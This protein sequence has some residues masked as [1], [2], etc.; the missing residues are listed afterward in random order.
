MANKGESLSKRTTDGFLCHLNELATD[1]LPT[2]TCVQS[3]QLVN[4][5]QYDVIIVG[6]GFAGLIAARELSLRQ[7]KVLLVEAKDRIGGRTFTAEYDGGK[8]EIGGTWVHWSQ[9]HVWT[10]ITRYGL[11]IIESKGVAAKYMSVLLDNGTKLKQITLADHWATLGKAMEKY[12]DVDNVQA[13]MVIP[14][15]HAPFTARENVE[16]Y[17]RLSMQD[18]F[19]QVRNTLNMTDE[20]QAML[21]ALL[22]MNMQ[23]NIAEGGFVDHLRWWALGDYDMIRMFDKLGRYKIKEGTSTLAQAILNDCQNVKLLLS[24]SV[25]SVDRTKQDSV[26]VRLQSGD[27]ILGRT[28]LVT[29]PLNV[30]KNIEFLPALNIK[31]QEI[32]AKGQCQGGTKFWAKLDKPIGHWF[33]M[34]PYPNP[35]TMAYTDDQ[36]GSVIVGFGP[37]GLLDIK[38]IKSVEKELNKFLPAVKAQYVLGHDWRTDPNIMG[39]WSWYKPGQ[40]CSN[41]QALQT[42]E[43]PVFFASGDIANGWRGFIDGALESGL[44]NAREIQQY[45]NK[46][47]TST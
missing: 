15:P 2:L 41:L 24:T 3:Q 12:S 25:V 28:V 27:L 16:K 5:E 14:L 11:S 34:A 37:E 18:R 42:C 19:D 1:G 32:A 31:K 20:I 22:S 4:T 36:D 38:D 8:F 9:P 39:T 7:R 44:N 17:D 10:E 46:H 13:R 21:L 29:V 45:L 30:L 35:I 40:M 43:P 33:A 47:F 6:A 23:G 26:I